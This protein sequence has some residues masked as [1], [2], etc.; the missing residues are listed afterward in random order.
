MFKRLMRALSREPKSKSQAKDRLKLIL[1]Q[2]RF[3]VS[4][5]VMRALQGELTQILSKYFE[6]D[7]NHIDMELQREDESMALVANIPV[8]GLKTR[9]SLHAE[10]Q[11]GKDLQS[12][13]TSTSNKCSTASATPSL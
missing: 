7:S 1:I 13:S 11:P 8:F 9:Q 4:E 10:A 12:D 6:L 3:G 2:D 5:E